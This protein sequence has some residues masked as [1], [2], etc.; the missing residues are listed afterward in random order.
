MT[1]SPSYAPHVA[2]VMLDAIAA[3]AYGTHHVVGGGATTWYAFAMR[4]FEASSL[5][6]VVEPVSYAAFPS[7]VRRPLY[8]ALASISLPA[9]GLSPARHWEAGLDAF[10]EERAKRRHLASGV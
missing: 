8:S 1:F 3:R 5:Q 2:C 6:P 4:A 7:A 9:A 10:L